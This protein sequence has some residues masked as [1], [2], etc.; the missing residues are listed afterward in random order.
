M[1]KQDSLQE[2]VEFLRKRSWDLIDRLDRLESQLN[3]SVDVKERSSLQIRISNTNSLLENYKKD[4]KKMCD[5]AGIPSEIIGTDVSGHDTT[6]PINSNIKNDQQIDLPQLFLVPSRN[7]MFR[8]RQNEIRKIIKQ[9]LKG[10]T[11]AICGSKGKSMGGIGKTEIAKEICHIFHDTSQ[12]QPDLPENLTDLLEQ[13]KGGF[14]R[15]GILWIQFHPEG[16]SPNSLIN[17][18]IEVL[19]PLLINEF[20]KSNKKKLI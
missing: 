12:D 11:F 14:F 10:E 13:K 6:P 3:T 2:K 17:W 19:N 8:G 20:S 15:D 1:S 5:Q 4:Y 9:V 7:P 18:L 16:Q